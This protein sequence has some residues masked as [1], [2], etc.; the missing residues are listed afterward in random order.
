MECCLPGRKSPFAPASVAVR[1]HQDPP[2]LLDRQDQQVDPQG[3]L[4]LED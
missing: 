1:G 3:R 2:D 4:G